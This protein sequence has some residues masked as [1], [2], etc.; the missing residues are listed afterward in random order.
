MSCIFLLEDDPILGQT[1]KRGLELEGY[2]V[3]WARDLRTGHSLR[4]QTLVDLYILDWN[5]SDG[6]GLS[7]CTQIRDDDKRVP[8]IFLTARTEEET[9]VEALSAGAH[10]FI[11]KPCGQAELLARAKRLLG[12]ALNLEELV[13][14]GDLT[15]HIGSRKARFK[16]VEFPLQRREFDVLVHLA[17]NGGVI[18][19]RDAILEILDPDQT[20][21]DRAVDAQMSRLRGRF[22][23]FGIEAIEIK[24]IYGQGYRLE[25]AS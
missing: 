9:A 14:F 13:R 5:L 20:I 7:F 15:L 19:S 24:S 8:I 17:R 4:G 1:V 10:D 25:K 12:E 11:R 3:V 16:N 22:R 23:E 21:T 2:T 6:T 18:S